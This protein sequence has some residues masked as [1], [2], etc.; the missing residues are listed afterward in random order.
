MFC[1]KSFLE[2][3]DLFIFKAND[4]IIL[5]HLKM[6][7]PPKPANNFNSATV[8]YMYG[9]Q[10]QILF[11]VRMFITTIYFVF[12]FCIMFVLSK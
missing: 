3:Y 1:L 5:Q 2:S 6:C 8:T 7:Y 10:Y 9:P 11:L 12:V 4:K